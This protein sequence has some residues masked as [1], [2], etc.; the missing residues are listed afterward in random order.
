MEDAHS[1][2]A[3]H[4]SPVAMTRRFLLRLFT[5]LIGCFFLLHPRAALAD[6]I[7]VHYHEGVKHGFLSLRSVEGKLLADGELA[8][9]TQGDRVTDVLTF[10]FKDGSAFEETTVFSQHASFRL[11]TDKVSQK[12]PAFPH[13]METSIDTAT[14]E[15]TVRTKGDNGKEETFNERLSLP[16]DVANGLL[17]VLLK[18]IPAK[19]AETMVSLVAFTPKPRLVN[20]AIAPQN[21]ESVSKGSIRDQALHYTMQ[22][23]I[24]AVA[25]WFA[26]LTGKKPAD[27]QGWVLRGRAPELVKFEGQFYAGG[28]V[29]Q[30]EMSAPQISAREP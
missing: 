9:T 29:W 20:L 16:A 2:A 22:F 6:Q 24:G 28:P 17:L 18:N 11:L 19:P 1:R 26:A 15:V 3:L 13:P 8:Q 30:I 21:D 5:A 23:R 27:F 7:P 4:A 12:G 10:R 25:G 14:G